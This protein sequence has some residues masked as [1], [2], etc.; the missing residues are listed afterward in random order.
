MVAIEKVFYKISLTLISEWCI[1]KMKYKPIRQKE[2]EMNRK[3]T[4]Q[5]IKLLGD[6]KA[7][8][9]WGD[10][11]IRE[12]EHDGISHARLMEF[13]NTYPVYDVKIGNNN[14]GEFQFITLKAIQFTN[15]GSRIN[16]SLQFWGNG[17]HE[18]RG[19]NIVNWQINV[20]SWF[21]SWY[22]D[23]KPMNKAEVKK[24]I[25]ERMESLGIKANSNQE[26]SGN[27]FETLADLTDDDFA[28][29]YI[30]E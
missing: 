15:D 2:S 23:S 7:D 5:A 21:E 27:T 1:Y 22:K 28:S 12:D 10:M 17:F 30:N 24:L 8:Y 13:I 20:N 9:L 4:E 14:Y 26:K 6:K 18:L 11:G 19:V 3:M 16:T 25:K 29:L